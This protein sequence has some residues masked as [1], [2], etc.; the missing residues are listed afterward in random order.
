MTPTT[1]FSALAPCARRAR[2][3]AFAALLAVLPAGCQSYSGRTEDALSDFREGQ[4]AGAEAQF[5]D[6]DF[7]GSEFL[8]GAEAGTVASAAGRWEAAIGHF[9]RAVAKVTEFEDEMIADPARAMEGIASWIINDNTYRY[10]GEGFERVYLHAFLGMA[11]LAQGNLDGVW[12]EKE[13][14]NQLLE[15]EEELYDTHYGAGGLGHFISAVAYEILGELDQAYIDYERM[16][17][18]GLGT[19]LAG[20]SL[21]RIA[22]KLRYDDRLTLWTERYGPPVSIEQD[23]ASIFVIGGIGVGPYKIQ[24]SITLP[25]GDGLIRIVVPDY[26]E[27]PQ[28]VRGLRLSLADTGDSLDT[29]EIEDVSAVAMHNLKDRLAWAA[30]KSTIRTFAKRELTQHLDDKYGGWGALAGNLFN[31]ITEQADLRCW[32]TLPDSWHGGHFFVPAGEHALRLEALGGE[33]VDLGRFR[34]DPGETMVILAR[35]VGRQLYAHPIGGERVVP[36]PLAVAQPADEPG[37]AD[38]VQLEGVTPDPSATP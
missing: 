22:D 1:A 20:R 5:A 28:S 29:V 11:Y 27:R 3:V 36:E 37:P 23:A 38:P 26:V 9:D 21:V 31:L 12:V 25:T 8:S 34:L 16:E 7:T 15:A 30:T 13:R 18:K 2:R 6:S 4:L 17:A 35:T 14:A 32:T 19:A 10:V 33:R 24:Q